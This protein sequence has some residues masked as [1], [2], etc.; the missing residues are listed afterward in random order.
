MSGPQMGPKTKR[1]VRCLYNIESHLRNRLK[2]FTRRSWP[3]SYVYAMSI[4]SKMNAL[5]RDY[6]L[7][8]GVAVSLVAIAILAGIVF[9]YIDRPSALNNVSSRIHHILGGQKLPADL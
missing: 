8:V 9:T 2:S 7:A 6:Y 3:T 4:P 1:T 5:R